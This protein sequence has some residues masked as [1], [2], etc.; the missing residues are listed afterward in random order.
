MSV[1]FLSQICYR[2]DDWPQPTE[3][4][5]RVQLHVKLRFFWTKKLKKYISVLFL[6]LLNEPLWCMQIFCAK[7]FLKRLHWS[8]FKVHLCH[9]EVNKYLLMYTNKYWR[10]EY[11]NPGFQN[12]QK[13]D[14]RLTKNWRKSC[15]KN[16]IKDIVSAYLQSKY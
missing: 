2:P 11:T 9:F 5:C 10:I 8:G 12:W 14:E 16:W 4:L 3:F 1:I 7:I 13:M 15:L 6:W